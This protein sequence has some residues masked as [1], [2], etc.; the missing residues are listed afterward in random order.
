[1]HD[2]LAD[3]HARR[4]AAICEA[5]TASM[6]AH[7]VAVYRDHSEIYFPRY[8]M[9]GRLGQQ[10]NHV[11]GSAE[12]FRLHGGLGWDAVRDITML[13]QERGTVP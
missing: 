11:A 6:R 4:A 9:S 7:D 1:M 10:D 5:L 3:R 2:I 12:V 8:H 13:Y